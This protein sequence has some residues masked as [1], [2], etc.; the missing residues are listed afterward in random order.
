MS[1]K[2][3]LLASHWWCVPTALMIGVRAELKRVLQDQEWNAFPFD[4][5][6]FEAKAKY[7]NDFK[8]EKEM[9]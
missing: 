8:M 4:D 6:C 5:L 7:S 3:F 9:K 1:G 2:V